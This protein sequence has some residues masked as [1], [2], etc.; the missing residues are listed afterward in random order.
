MDDEPFRVL[1]GFILFKQGSDI[2]SRERRNI[3]ANEQL[4][5]Y[6]EVGG[7][8]P[9]C[10][11]VLVYEKN[12]RN[13][14]GFEI[15]HIYPLNPLQKEV[16]LLKD[17]EILN[18]DLDH[19][20]NLICLCNPC[21]KKYDK[22]KSVQE[23]CELV[24]VKKDILK[25]K[26]EQ[27]IWTKT[28]IEK[29]IFEI[30][31]LLVA[32]DLEF[33]DNLEYSPKTIDNKTNSSITLLTKRRI[34]QNV[35]DYFYKISA[36]FKELDSLEPMTTEVISSQIKTH[37]LL[38]RKQ[39]TNQKE[40]YDAMVVWLKKQTKQEGNEACEIIISFFIQNCEIF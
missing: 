1:I 30:I 3:Q 5:L 32:Q 26:K 12:G 27:E 40:I 11:T 31:D 18:S 9:L 34:H 13:Q 23:Y 17:E 24:K 25:R 38:L 16:V 15:A 19:S 8:C 10:P 20:D 35:Q 6:S 39:G 14:K 4:I 36:K 22:D 2:V 37:Y 29:E 21:H 28:S 33:D 7:I